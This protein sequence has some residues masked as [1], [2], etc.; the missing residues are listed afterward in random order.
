[1][2]KILYLFY[3]VF[4]IFI[5]LIF[6]ILMGFICL[7]YIHKD[8]NYYAPLNKLFE[9]SQNNIPEY[10]YYSNNRLINIYENEKKLFHFFYKNKKYIATS[11][12]FIIENENPFPVNTNFFSSI[13]IKSPLF[14]FGET[15]IQRISNFLNYT[16]YFFIDKNYYIFSI[17]RILIKLSDFIS[18][19]CDTDLMWNKKLEEA[20]IKIKNDI[21]KLQKKKITD[22]YILDTRLFN[23][24]NIIIK[25]KIT[26][27]EFDELHKI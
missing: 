14:D 18:L 8:V 22:G 26:K 5:F 19:E 15:D 17:H 21:E 9:F 1:M 13:Y 10:S 2:K 4:Y 24:K 7:K 6:H 25:K 3:P 11:K 20:L 16:R 27:G 12:Q 23:K